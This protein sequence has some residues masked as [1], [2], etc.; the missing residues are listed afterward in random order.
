MHVSK[1]SSC[2]WLSSLN[3]ADWMLIWSPLLQFP[4]LRRNFGSN[5]AWLEVRQVLWTRQFLKQVSLGIVII[6]A[7]KWSVNILDNVLDVCNPRPNG[8]TKLTTWLKKKQSKNYYWTQPQECWHSISHESSTMQLTC[9]QIAPTIQPAHSGEQYKIISPGILH[10]YKPLGDSF[11]S[12]R[13]KPSDNPELDI[14][15][16]VH[17][18][19][20]LQG[21][22]GWAVQAYLKW[23]W[24]SAQT[25]QEPG[26]ATELLPKL[27]WLHLRKQG[28]VNAIKQ[29][30]LSHFE[31]YT[32]PTWKRA[33][34]LK[35]VFGLSHVMLPHVALLLCLL[36][37]LQCQPWLLAPHHSC[38]CNNSDQKNYMFR[39]LENMTWKSM[40]I[41]KEK[42]TP[43]WLVMSCS[44]RWMNRMSR[45]I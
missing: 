8:N 12:W 13:W 26:K 9:Q 24:P 21:P 22:A 2:I 15:L 16:M 42:S 44:S 27:L 34:F 31:K 7:S 11:A 37:Y 5:T 6:Y 23:T 20:H 4:N 30:H 41:F 18:W 43:F 1:C 32:S 29:T 28:I 14:S 25:V 33:A 45:R 10:E 38:C 3:A 17:P 35:I 36:S 19:D 40:S 39:K